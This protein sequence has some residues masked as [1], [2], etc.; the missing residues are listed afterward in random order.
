MAT[1]IYVPRAFG[2]TLILQATVLPIITTQVNAYGRDGKV[3]ARGR[4][5]KVNAIGR[6]GK[7]VGRGH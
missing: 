2:S 3:N 4:D 5:G 1:T 6:D 7:V